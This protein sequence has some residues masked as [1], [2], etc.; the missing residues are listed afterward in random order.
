MDTNDIQNYIDNYIRENNGKSPSLEELNNYIKSYVENVNNLQLEEF[1]GLTPAEMEYII[2]DP[3]NKS[4]P[5]QFNTLTPEEYNLS[6]IFRQIKLLLSHI[7]KEGELNLT[8]TGNIPPRIVKEM[9]PLGVADW[10][11]ESSGSKVSKE[12]DSWSVHLARL[13][14]ETSGIVKKRNNKLSLTANGKKTIKND[15]ALFLHLFWF[16]CERFNW[17]YFDRYDD[18]ESMG[19]I[20]FPFTLYLL[21]KYGNEERME[22]F[23]AEKYINAF[24]YFTEQYEYSSELGRSKMSALISC[25]NSRVF[26]RT[27]HNWGFIERRIERGSLNFWSKPTE[28]FEKMIRIK[29][30]RE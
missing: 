13:V 3:L 4:S 21:A 8:A 1:E 14:A 26:M 6:P 5:V 10:I 7:E 11:I 12:T 19:Q 22:S 23:Y 27:L 16:Y 29:E 24:S 28:L 15:N 18:F 2:R 9:Y 20:G 25:Y 30:I 17:G